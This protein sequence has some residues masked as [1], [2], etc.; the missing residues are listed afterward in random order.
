MLFIFAVLLLLLSLWAVF[1]FQLSR[2]AGAIVLMVVLVVCAFLKSV[3]TDSWYP[4]HPD[5]PRG[6][7]RPFAHVVYFQT[8]L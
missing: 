4:A 5:Q 3:V 2:S 7:N 8:G 1:Y 6:D